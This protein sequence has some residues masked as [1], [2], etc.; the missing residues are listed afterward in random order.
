MKK[1]VDLMTCLFMAVGSILFFMTPFS[2]VKYYT[3][4]ETIESTIESILVAVVA[5]VLWPFQMIIGASMLLLMAICSVVVMA[6]PGPTDKL[7][8]YYTRIVNTNIKFYQ[9]DGE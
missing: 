8:Q 4:N 2:F 7:Q 9:K 5:I 3:S 6:T 1:F